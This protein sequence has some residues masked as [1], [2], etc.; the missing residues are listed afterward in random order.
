VI[1]DS[2][3][4]AGYA[5]AESGS[6]TGISRST[7]GALPA[8]NAEQLSEGCVSATNKPAETS[9]QARVFHR[10]HHV[11][12]CQ[13]GQVDRGEDCGQVGL[14]VP[15]K[16]SDF[17]AGAS[18]VGLRLSLVSL[19]TVAVSAVAHCTLVSAELVNRAVMTGFESWPSHECWAAL[20]ASVRFRRRPR[21]CLLGAALSAS[22]AAR[23]VAASPEANDLTWLV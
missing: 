10:P 13:L 16:V 6:L 22:A 9:M 1:S 20:A 18:E 19:S 4:A 12:V 14:S 8:L 17:L 15:A 7:Q 2:P 21:R 5:F 23:A 3:S 11:S